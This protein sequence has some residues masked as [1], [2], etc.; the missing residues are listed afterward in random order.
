MFFRHHNT[1]GRGV[2]DSVLSAW[3]WISSVSCMT[4]RHF[5]LR[6]RKILTISGSRETRRVSRE[7]ARTPSLWLVLAI[8]EDG[9]TRYAA[10]RRTRHHKLSVSE[11]SPSY[12]GHGYMLTIPREGDTEGNASPTFGDFGSYSMRRVYRSPPSAH[13]TSL[14]RS[15]KHQASSEK[16]E[17]ALNLVKSLRNGF[18]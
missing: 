16:D 11:T 1:S 18:S 5:S 15:N 4:E 6:T 10:H 7:V 2:T 3:F 14:I 17:G 8:S 12:H 13:R 9:P